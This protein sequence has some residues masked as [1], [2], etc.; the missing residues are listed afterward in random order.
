MWHNHVTQEY[1]R[2]SLLAYS[3]AH[4]PAGWKHT[5]A[6]R[7]AAITAAAAAHASL[8]QGSQPIEEGH[9]GSMQQQQ[10]AASAEASAAGQPVGPTS[11]APGVLKSLFSAGLVSERPSHDLLTTS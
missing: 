11:N 7:H 3:A 2:P 6:A 1:F 8:L 10:A 5:A 9:A 4:L